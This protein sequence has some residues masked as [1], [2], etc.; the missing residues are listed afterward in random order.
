MSKEMYQFKLSFEGNLVEHSVDAFDL[1]NTILATSAALQEI[2]EIRYGTEKAQE[3]KIHIN[4]F[5]QGSHISEFLIFLQNNAGAIIPL[6][7][8]FA[9]KGYE[10]GKEIISTITT[11]IKV[12][13]MLKGK[14]PEIIQ[15]DNS[16]I[17]I[18]GNGNT[19]NINNFDFRAL[20]SKTVSRNI[21][22]AI[23]PLLKPQSEITSI[24]IS[25]EGKQLSEIT[26][27]TAP[28]LSDN[29]DIQTVGNIKYKGIISKIDTKVCS[30]YIDVG[31]KRIPFNYLKNIDQNKFAILVESLRSKIQI[32]LIGEVIMDYENNPKFLN[33]IDVQSDL[34]LFE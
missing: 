24:K 14:K 31:S 12:K 13:E 7:P 26:K 25:E 30:G 18:K 10:I 9:K 15:L 17:Q 27:E 28:Y 21:T 4:A 29:E 34:K 5:Q 19:V 2:A 20:Q 3:I 16:T 11:L 8:E 33:V 1:A 32:Y 6:I 23:Q 22:K